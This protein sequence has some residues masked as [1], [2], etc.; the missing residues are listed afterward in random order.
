MTGFSV[1]KNV[2]IINSWRLLN[3]FLF[4]SLKL[5]LL[6]FLIVF[7]IGAKPLFCVRALAD[8]LFGPFEQIL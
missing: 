3:F 6:Y 4:G 1:A 8:F 5:N 7:I 2:L